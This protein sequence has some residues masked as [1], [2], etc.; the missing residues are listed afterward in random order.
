MA[1][2]SNRD[3]SPSRVQRRLGKAK[4]A[5]RGDSALWEGVE[6]DLAVVAYMSKGYHKH[7]ARLLAAID[8]V[9]AIAHKYLPELVAAAIA[10]RDAEYL[11]NNATRIALRRKLNGDTR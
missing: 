5:E 8:A 2:G 6:Q 11:N 7:I 3:H 10:A 4:R 9:P 1:R